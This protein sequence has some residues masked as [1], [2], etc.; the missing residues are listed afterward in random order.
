MEHT[1][2]NAKECGINEILQLLE[3]IEKVEKVAKL[4]QKN[5]QFLP[6]KWEPNQRTIEVRLPVSY[7]QWP[8]IQ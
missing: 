1:R 4:G 5:A 3:K 8:T 2:D 7:R 6:P